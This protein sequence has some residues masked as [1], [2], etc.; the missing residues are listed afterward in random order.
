MRNVAGALWCEVLKARRSRVPLL[1]A[2]GFLLA[3]LMGGFVMIILKDPAFARRVGILRT[4]AEVLSGTADWPSYFGLLAQ[5]TAVGGVL[6]FAL[7][8]SWVFGR[9]FVDRTAKDLL[10]LPTPR[11]S[12]VSAKFVVSMVWTLLLA[13]EVFGVGL[14]VGGIIGLPEWSGSVFAEAAATM[15]VVTVLS[16][17]L[18][19]PIAFIAGASRGYLAP[20]GFAIVV[21]VLAQVL[22][23]VGWGPFF[24]WSVPALS[25]GLGEPQESGLPLASYCTV[26]VTGA[27]G[28]LA[29]FLWWKYADHSG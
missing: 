1:S 7:I 2:L 10:A 9:E 3:P 13:L 6:V 22:A 27:A 26:L 20:M 15:G 8:T 16:M 21:L 5:A 17:I 18:L 12:I 19:P 29:T 14:A 4:K 28:T 24:P 23:A 25:A 11:S